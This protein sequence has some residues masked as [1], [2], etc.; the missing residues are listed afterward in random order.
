MAGGG[1]AGPHARA[2]AQPAAAA[3]S[4]RRPCARVKPASKYAGKMQAQC[5]TAPFSTFSSGLADWMVGIPGFSRIMRNLG[6]RCVG[7]GP[8]V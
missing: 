4:T 7:M 5:F 8:L 1:G 6:S 2:H 3:F